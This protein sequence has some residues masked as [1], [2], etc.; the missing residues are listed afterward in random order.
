LEAIVTRELAS[1]H[2]SLTMCLVGCDGFYNSGMPTTRLDPDVR[3]ETRTGSTDE[4]DDLS[5]YA[6]REEIMKANVNGGK[7]VA[8]CGYEFEPVRDPTRYPVC[9]RCKELV[10]MAEEFG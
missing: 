6:R 1:E 3:P 7:I 5:H 9:P 2:G 10:E 8:L 4:G